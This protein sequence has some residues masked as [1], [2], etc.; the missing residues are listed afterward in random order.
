MEWITIVLIIAGFICVLLGMAG[1]L[2]PVLPGP[3]ISLAGLIMLH[4]SGPDFSLGWFG[5]TLAIVTTLVGVVVDY[6]IPSATVKVFGGTRAGAT[7][8]GIGQ[9]IGLYW[10]LWG[11]IIGSFVGTF[12]GESAKQQGWKQSL[13]S[14]L[15]STLGFIVSALIKLFITFVH[16]ILFI[17]VF[18]LGL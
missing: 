9:I 10:G 15:G 11:S 8:A 4:Y 18:F 3:P 6:V 14:S 17:V 5:W 12:A 7:G 16:L 2:L 13:K 1:S